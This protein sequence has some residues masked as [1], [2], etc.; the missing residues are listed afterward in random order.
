MKANIVINTRMHDIV[1][2][3]HRTSKH[4]AHLYGL[5]EFNCIKI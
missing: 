5:Y 3:S 1:G 4:V 2:V